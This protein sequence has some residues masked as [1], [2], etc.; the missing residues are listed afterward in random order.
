MRSFLEWGW[1]SKQKKLDSTRAQTSLRKAKGRSVIGPA[2]RWQINR[3]A[4][5][6]YAFLAL[7]LFS[8]ISPIIPEPRSQ[9]AFGIGTTEECAVV[10]FR[11]GP[12]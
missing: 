3:G 1:E 6:F 8:P 9:A 4:V 10:S 7:L 2:S 12:E 11:S 5:F